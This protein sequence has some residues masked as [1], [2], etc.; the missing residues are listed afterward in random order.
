[1]F[2][3]SNSMSF[4]TAEKKDHVAHC[5]AGGWGG[6]TYLGNACL[7]TFFSADVFPKDKDKDKDNGKDHLLLLVFTH[8]HTY[9]VPNSQNQHNLLSHKIT[10]RNFWFI[11]IPILL[12]YEL[13]NSVMSIHDWFCAIVISGG[14]WWEI[15]HDLNHFK[16]AIMNESE[17]IEKEKA[18]V[19]KL[20][21]GYC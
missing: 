7:K 20:P 2:L 17:E 1:M 21:F 8:S 13:P 9:G 15:F 3:L 14:E 6:Q 11:T 19:K 5:S 18:W 16:K 12:C 10:R 4:L